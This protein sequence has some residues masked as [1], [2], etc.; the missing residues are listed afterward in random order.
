MQSLARSLTSNLCASTLSD[1][2]QSVGPGEDTTGLAVGVAQV[3]FLST[4][5]IQNSPATY[6]RVK[7]E[8]LA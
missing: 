7:L 1:P 8:Y 4:A 6:N 3:E 2:L 5:A